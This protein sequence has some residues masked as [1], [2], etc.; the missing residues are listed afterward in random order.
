[1]GDELW[2]NLW[3]KKSTHHS[4]IHFIKTPLWRFSFI[5]P[6]LPWLFK[7]TSKEHFWREVWAIWGRIGCTA[8]ICS[9]QY[10]SGSI[11][12]SSHY[13]RYTVM[14]PFSILILQ[15]I[16]LATLLI[17]HVKS[18]KLGNTSRSHLNWTLQHA[19][20]Y[21]APHAS[22]YQYHTCFQFSAMC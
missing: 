15:T 11:T 1:V 2:Y 12:I 8:T 17:L 20:H 3:K 7:M 9:P 14:R 22:I 5:C 16:P 21:L 19:W 18:Q 13:Y 4:K 10:F 6:K